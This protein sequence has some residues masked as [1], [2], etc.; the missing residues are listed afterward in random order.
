MSGNQ[1][2]K[3][4]SRGTDSDERYYTEGVIK[5][6]QIDAKSDTVKFLIEPSNGYSLEIENKGEKKTVV[7]LWSEKSAKQIFANRVAGLYVDDF[8]FSINKNMREFLFSL[9]I[10]RC[11]VRVCV[12]AGKIDALIDTLEKSN[13][14][15]RPEVVVTELC[16]K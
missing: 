11:L 6:L 13:N 9:K 14:E 2:K 10:N 12:D 1:R 8:V 16:I 7:V 15:R 3:A 5:E 4:S